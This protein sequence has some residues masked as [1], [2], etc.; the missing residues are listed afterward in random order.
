MKQDET[1]ALLLFHCH[2]VPSSNLCSNWI[3]KY[4]LTDPVLF[5]GELELPFVALLL[6]IVAPYQVMNLR[7]VT[8]YN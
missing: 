4:I 3:W 1:T 2:Y 5:L 7:F 6:V 8:A